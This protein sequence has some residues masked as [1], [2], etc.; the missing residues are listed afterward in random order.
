MKTIAVVSQKG[1][2]GKSLLASNLI[3]SAMRD[4]L[5]VVGLDLDRQGT[6]NLWADDRPTDDVLVDSIGAEQLGKLSSILERLEADG[7]QVAVL[8]CPG[9]DNLVTSL[10]VKAATLCLVPVT[11]FRPDI[12][13]SFA[14]VEALAA[15]KKAP[16]FVLNKVPPGERGTRS[17]EAVESLSKI[18]RVAPV[19][20]TQRMD[21]NDAMSSGLGVMEYAPRGK[22]AAEMA[23]LWAWIK[24]EGS[25]KNAKK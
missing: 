16:V 20:L 1:G 3:V 22:S 19:H 9:A 6:L 2:A 11:P 17:L 5:R 18:G 15:A 23:D 10:A 8:D 13:A 14:T 7:C 12:L 25:R 24:K 21:F 4:G